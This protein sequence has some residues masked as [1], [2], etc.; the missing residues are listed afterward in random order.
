VFLGEAELTGYGSPLVALRIPPPSPADPGEN[1]SR[2]S[3]KWSHY[4]LRICL[5]ASVWLV[6]AGS[7]PSAGPPRR[8]MAGKSRLDREAKKVSPVQSAQAEA[9][10]GEPA[11]VRLG[12]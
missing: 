12:L 1:T 6:I 10:M 9:T 7:L 11:H 8:A 2:G 4:A 5:V 3:P